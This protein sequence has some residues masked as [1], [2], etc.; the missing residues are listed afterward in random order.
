M[1]FQLLPLRQDFL[2]KARVEGLDDQGQPVRRYHSTEGGEPCR[3][4][5]RRARPGEEVILASYC[6]YEQDGPY[7]EY[8]PIF[9]LAE[10]SIVSV[11]P[12]LYDAPQLD[13]MAAAADTAPL[14]AGE[15][16]RVMDL[17]A[18]DFYLEPAADAAVFA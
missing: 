4:V 6:P 10:P 9:I 2:H 3:D 18:H 7:K 11:L 8:G 14:D 17:Y 5:L 16:E 12:N 15:Y 13:E 1:K